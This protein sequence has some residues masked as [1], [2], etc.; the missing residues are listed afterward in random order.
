MVEL[1]FKESAGTFAEPGATANIEGSSMADES[2]ISMS[3]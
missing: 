2:E 1:E 3:S